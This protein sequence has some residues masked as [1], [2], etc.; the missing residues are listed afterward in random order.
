[1]ITAQITLLAL[2]LWIT[3]LLGYMYKGYREDKKKYNYK[4][5]ETLDDMMGKTIYINPDWKDHYAGMT[6]MEIA[7]QD[8]RERKE[9]IKNK[10]K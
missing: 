8:D 10:Y 5:M 4:T 3:F 9:K 7:K 1:M 6:N 2:I